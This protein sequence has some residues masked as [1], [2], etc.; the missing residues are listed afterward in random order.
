MLVM[1]GFKLVHYTKAGKWLLFDLAAD[2]H[3][4]T[5]LSNDPAHAERLEGMRKKLAEIQR[6][7]DDPLAG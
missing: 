3:E 5:D 1:D 2:P 4:R 7:M 6:E